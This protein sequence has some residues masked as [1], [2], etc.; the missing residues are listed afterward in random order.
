MNPPLQRAKTLQ[1][2]D[3]ERR[4]FK[5]PIAVLK[6]SISLEHVAGEYTDL[7][8]AGEDRLVGHCPIPDHDDRSPSFHLYTSSQRFKCFGCGQSGDVLDLES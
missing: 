2:G 5:R 8:P 7:R 4:S 1:A 3:I 6:E